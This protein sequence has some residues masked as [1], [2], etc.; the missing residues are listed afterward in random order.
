MSRHIALGALITAIFYP[1]N[2]FRFCE[3]GGNWLSDLCSN[4]SVHHW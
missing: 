2:Y 1:E 3:G 4:T